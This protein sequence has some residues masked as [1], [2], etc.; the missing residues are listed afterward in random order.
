MEDVPEAR[1][2]LT[3][4]TDVNAK[5]SPAV[6]TLPHSERV[7]E[8]MLG[9]SPLCQSEIPAQ[10]RDTDALSLSLGYRCRDIRFHGHGMVLVTSMPGVRLRTWLLA[11][12]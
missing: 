8:Q 1:S 6:C 2:A 5:Y 3:T 11:C 7:K 10:E 9:T 4:E 12:H